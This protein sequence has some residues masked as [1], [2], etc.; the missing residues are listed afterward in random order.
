MYAGG[1]RR[2]S[3]RRNFEYENFKKQPSAGG[4]MEKRTRPRRETR[5]RR[6]GGG[7]TERARMGGGTAIKRKLLFIPRAG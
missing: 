4:P 6:C 1:Y 3:A 5:K 7:G 2:R